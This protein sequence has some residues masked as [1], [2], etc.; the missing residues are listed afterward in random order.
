[1]SSGEIAES[2]AGAGALMGFLIG[3]PIG[4][5]IGAAITSSDSGS[6]YSSSRGSY[7]NYEAQYRRQEAELRR[8]EQELQRR[9]DEERRRREEEERQRRREEERQRMIAQAWKQTNAVLQDEINSVKNAPEREQLT[10]SLRSMESSYRQAMNRNDTSS[11]ENIVNGLRQKILSVQSDEKLL[12]SQRDEFSRFLSRLEEEAPEGFASELLEL[13]NGNNVSGHTTIEEQTKLVK[14]LMGKAKKLANEAAQA[15]ALSL[16]GLVEEI[17]FIPPVVDESAV[18]S[19]AALKASLIQDICDFGGRVAFFDE[20]E[21]DRLKPLVMEAKQE[22]NSAR[23]KL[24]RSQI[25]TTYGRLREQA[26][27]TDM[28][29]QDIHS[30]LPPMQKAKETEKLCVRMED[31]LTASVITREEYNEVYKAVKTTFTEQFEAI[32]DALFAEKIGQTLEGMGYAL[33]DGQG[34][35]AELE[36]GKMRMISTPYDG[37]RVRV[38]V[39]KDNRLV[40]RLVRVVGSEEEKAAIS[41]YQRQKDVETGKKWCHDLDKFYKALENEGIAMTTV[42]RKEP[43][44]EPLDIVVDKSM[45]TQHRQAAKQRKEQL[46]ER[47]RD[48]H[49]GL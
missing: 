12:T 1:M 20:D 6:S 2:G 28:F 11:A 14:K 7:T 16:E 3:G 8:R 42:M 41:E 43:E 34:N 29:K 36:A 37:Y 23:L 48:A 49:A 17:A 19:E 5:I 44:E 32:T 33:M 38:K 18:E 10:A 9:L 13:R 31:L 15:N 30:F 40:T 45:R 21:A 47:G 4:A 27:L 39:N 46:E 25:K 35:P 22:A 24:I 26:I